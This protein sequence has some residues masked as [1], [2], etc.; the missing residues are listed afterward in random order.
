ML[1]ISALLLGT[2]T[3]AW[4]SMNKTVTAT[5]MEIT[6][7]SA[8]PYLVVNEEADETNTS[9]GT[10]ADAMATYKTGTGTN[11]KLVTPLNVESNV[12]YFANATD[13]TAGVGN[14]TTP[15]TFTT[16]SSILWGTT[17]SSNPAQV[18]ASNTP[19]LV[20]GT[21]F[22][23]GSLTDYVLQNDLYFKVLPGNVNGTNL[24]C[25]SVTF[26]NPGSNSIEGAGRVL[27][28]GASGRYQLFKFTN[29]TATAETG[30]SAALFDSVTQTATDAHV[31]IYF[32]FDGTDAESYTNNATDLDEIQATFTFDIA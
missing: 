11:L 3:F 32:Y 28:V 18:Q 24:T 5:N 22:S 14:E 12:D 25:T 23:N 26:S 1:L 30:S 17:T 9:F 19:D 4:F 20:G 21:G 2:S 27:V 7:T 31:V 8:N 13:R 10:A 15:S 29:G 6:A 16:A